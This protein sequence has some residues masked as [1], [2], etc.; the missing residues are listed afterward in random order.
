MQ[1]SSLAR[2]VRALAWTALVLDALAVLASRF[3]PWSVVPGFH[4]LILS[5]RAVPWVVAALVPV[6]AVHALLAAA[7][8]QRLRHGREPLSRSLT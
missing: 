5:P 1:R 8:W 6:V 4:H 3:V 7:V 2:H